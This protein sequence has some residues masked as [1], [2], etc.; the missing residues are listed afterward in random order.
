MS[1]KNFW[2]IVGES[3]ELSAGKV[4]GRTLLEEW[5]AIYRDESGRI[6]AIRDRCLHRNARL[7]KG[8]I[9]RGELVCPYHGWR[10]G[11]NGTVTGIP[12]EGSDFIPKVKCA[13]TF[14]TI[15]KDGY[16][17]VRLNSSEETKALA[18]FAVPSLGKKGF[19]HIRLKHV[20]RANVPNCAENFID[21]PHTTY[22][23]PGV[24]RYEKTPQ[25]ISAE[26]ERENGNVHIRYRGETSNFGWFS[27]ILN[28]S[29]REI[30]HEDHYYAPNVT[31]VEYR[32]GQ[33][34]NFNITSQSIPVGP[35]ETHVYTDL[36]YDYGLLNLIARPFVQWAA[37]KIIQQDVTIMGQQTDVMN[38]YG[39]L[40]NSTR[41]DL[42]H[43]WIE[44]IY[45]DIESGKDLRLTAPK[46]DVIE[47]FI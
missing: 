23:H 30:F 47:F 37:R 33:Q 1:L 22:V 13:T 44:K 29:D 12:S 20:F 7:S 5:I 31:H 40:F 45:S 9:A 35:Q 4:L 11:Q 16:I 19:Q 39:Q 18:P 6:N 27:K 14:E 46:K 2:Y 41:S 17:Y 10:Y 43:L 25:K 38:K 3:R 34:W 21:V 36:T 32:F 8:R 15:E 26:L 28:P 24:F 42:H